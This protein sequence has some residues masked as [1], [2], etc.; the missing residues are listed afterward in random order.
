MKTIYLKPKSK[1]VIQNAQN[2]INAKKKE[3]NPAE[4]EEVYNPEFVAKILQSME[5]SK[6]GKG[7]IITKEELRAL[8]K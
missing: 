3:S 2:V 8:W 6:N 5:D 1:K 4:E 7:R